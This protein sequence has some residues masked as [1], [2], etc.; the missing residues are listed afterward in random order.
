MS[1]LYE[2]TGEYL[3]LLDMMD[4][5][6]IPEDVIRD[7]LEGLDGEIDIKA[8]NY[9]KLIRNLES[10]VEA[11]KKEADRFTAKRKVVENNIERLKNALRMIMEVTGKKEIK[12]DLF[13]LK[14]AKVG[15]L[16]RLSVDVDLDELPED[17]R[18]KQPD[19]VNG[20]LLR[21]YI[22]TNGID[23]ACEYAHL[24]PQGTALKIK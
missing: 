17:F 19:K 21:E 13:T 3:T 15:G 2:L 7:T 1:S 8:E 24:E 12:T 6:D 20:D 22:E 16:R 18:I 14:L 5:P 23:D 4:D 9:C 10:D 11:F